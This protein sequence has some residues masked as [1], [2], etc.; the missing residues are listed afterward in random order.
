[1]KN[2]NA[3]VLVLLC[4]LDLCHAVS[5]QEIQL[6]VPNALENVEGNVDVTPDE[7]DLVFENG[8]RIQTV[9]P[10]SEFQSLPTSYRWLVGNRARPDQNV[11]TQ[12]TVEQ[13][14]WLIRISTTQKSPDDLSFVFSENI[15]PDEMVVFD[16]PLTLTADPIGIPRPFDFVIDYQ[17]PFF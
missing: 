9:Y 17:T 4:L 1:M 10:A 13:T 3:F 6:V 12:R 14:N 11:T 2:Y 8:L 16:G 5:A 15:G 7:L